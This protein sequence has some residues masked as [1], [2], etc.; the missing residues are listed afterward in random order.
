VPL[1]SLTKNKRSMVALG[2]L[3]DLITVCLSHPAAA[4]QTFLV[5]DGEDLST[6]A[7]L[8]RTAV[9]LGVNARLFS[10][11][12]I[13]LKSIAKLFGKEAVY[14]RLCRS[15]QIDMTKTQKLLNWKPPLSVQ[16]GLSLAA[17]GDQ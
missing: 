8:Q 2:N 5:S 9:A 1:G 11:P 13:V 14:Q 7:L 16:N 6:A 15:L 17:R 3:V 4:N 12:P 10:V